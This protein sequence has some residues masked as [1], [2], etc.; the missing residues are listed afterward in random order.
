MTTEGRRY[1]PHHRRNKMD[2]EKLFQ[3]A[4]D[5]DWRVLV[6]SAQ[7]GSNVLYGFKNRGVDDVIEDP[8]WRV[9]IPYHKEILEGFKNGDKVFCGCCNGEITEMRRS[10][11]FVAIGDDAHWQ[12]AEKSDH[13]YAEDYVPEAVTAALCE[14]CF[15]DG[16]ERKKIAEQSL[17]TYLALY[18]LENFF[19]TQQET[20]SEEKKH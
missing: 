5:R 3:E 1:P 13:G 2:F 15:G 9:I 6:L 19:N 18:V 16:K 12:I 17:S 7:E 8:I 10:P 11:G 20:N 4:E 14:A